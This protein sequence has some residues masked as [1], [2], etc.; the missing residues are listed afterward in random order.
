MG[1]FSRSATGQGGKRSESK[2]VKDCCRP[3]KVVVAGI[4]N[5]IWRLSIAA[6]YPISVHIDTFNASEPLAPD[7]CGGALRGRTHR[8]WCGEPLDVKGRPPLRRP[9]YL[10]WATDRRAWEQ[11]LTAVKPPRL[12]RSNQ[13]ADGATSIPVKLFC[14]VCTILCAPRTLV[15]LLDTTHWSPL[16]G[17]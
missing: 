15:I 13:S 7:T 14:N 5:G 3:G 1:G 6:N 16:T 4:D 12:T 2:V 10:K 17:N 9:I 8:L 11:E